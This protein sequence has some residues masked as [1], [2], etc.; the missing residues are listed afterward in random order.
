M[1]LHVKDDHAKRRAAEYP[2]IGEQLEAIWNALNTSGKPL[3]P[4]TQAVFDRI[5]TVKAKYPKKG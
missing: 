4:E 3:P 5:A 2:P 1:K